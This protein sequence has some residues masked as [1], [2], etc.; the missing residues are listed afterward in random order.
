MEEK[1]SGSVHQMLQG[2]YLTDAVTSDAFEIQ[3]VLKSSGY[4][5]EIFANLDY[6]C[7]ECKSKV[8]DYKKYKDYSSS[9]N[10]LIYHYAT[11]SVV[12]GFVL[13]L[14]DR[15]VL[16]YH[17]IT[18][19]RYFQ[20]FDKGL[21]DEL[22]K[23][24][25]DL[26]RLKNR[27]C[28]AIA[29]SEFN[30]MDLQNLGFTQT[31]VLPIVIDFEK[32][33]LKYSKKIYERLKDSFI[34][35]LFVGRIA[36]NKKC[37]DLLKIFYYFREINHSSNLILV[38]S[39][40]FS[41]EYFDYLQYVKKFLDLENVIFTGTVTNSELISYYK[42]SD[43][44]LNMSEHEGFCVPLVEAMY[45]GI[46]I[47]AYNSSAVPF[48]LDGAGILVDQKCYREIAELMDIVLK[49]SELKESI[50]RKERERLTYF[51]NENIKEML[52]GYVN[53]ASS[54]LGK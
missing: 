39:Y 51:G 41:K 53:L 3:K 30:K 1:F 14:P 25:E 33:S 54:S 40:D 17:N 32:F 50:I 27:V 6:V 4:K 9:N 28:F 22:E 46:P 34:N 31:Y 48:T 21:K 47:V 44:F 23:G 7:S 45:F 37:E 38:G 15:L 16:R 5:S 20:W 12:T 49:N 42:V 11:Y 24:K 10:I 43:L 2:M 52:K 8:Y 26:L 36:P 18:P 13:D 29:D 35:I 19:H